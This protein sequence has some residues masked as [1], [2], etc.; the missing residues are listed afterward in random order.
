MT[1]EQLREYQSKRTE[2]RELR[3]KLEHLG[4]ENSLTNSDVILDYKSGYPIP[5]AIVGKE[6]E[7]YWRLRDRYR[8]QIEKLERECTE[9]E[10]YIE[11]IPDS[12]TRQIFRMM[13]LEGKTQREIGEVT[14][15]ERSSISKKVKKIFEKE[16]MFESTAKP[17]R[18]R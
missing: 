1:R 11:E 13:F 15:L 17:K 14:N 9:M 8:H 2:I 3:Y 6:W 5:Q 10:E 12:M 7:R 18:Q 16:N 4:E